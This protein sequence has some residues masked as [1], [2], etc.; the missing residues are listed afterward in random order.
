VNELRQLDIKRCLLSDQ[1]QLSTRLRGLKRYKNDPDRYASELAKLNEAISISTAIVDKRK[2]SIPAIEFPPD[3]P[4]SEQRLVIAEAMSKNQ[5]IILAGDTGSGKTTQLPK[6]CLQL[7]L[8]AR[9]L[10]GHTQPRRLAARSVS[11]RIADEL[12]VAP[13]TL[14]GCQVRFS[15]NTSSDTLVKLM[16]DGILLAEI[17]QD[18]YLN[19]YEVLI[20]DEAHERSLNIDFLL[21]YLFQLLPKRPDLKL[22]ITSATIDVEK[23]SKHFNAAP[24]ITVAGRTFPVDIYYRPP[25]P[26]TT[27][28]SDLDDTLISSIRAAIGEIERLE[29][30][31][32]TLFGDIL[33]FLSG[34]REIRDLSTEFRKSP[35]RNT[36]ILPLYARLSATEQSRI[37]SPHTGRRLILSTNVAETSLTVPGIVYVIDTGLARISRYSPQSKVQRLP[38]EAISQSSANQRAGRCGRVS[39]GICIRLYSEDDYAARPLYTDP[40][41]LRTNLSAVILQMLMLGLGDVESFPFLDQPDQKSIN[42]GF[43]LLYELGAVDKSRKLSPMGRRMAALPTDPRLSRMLL[44]AGLRKCLPEALV[45][46]SA[47]SVQDPREFPPDK[48]QAAREKHGQFT[49]HESD[50]TAWLHLWSAFEKQRVNLSHS[51]LRQFCQKNFLSY[52]RLREWRETHRQ[53]YLS[54]Q[55]IGVRHSAGNAAIDTENIDYEAIHRA[56]LTGSLNQIGQKLEEGAYLGVRGRKF[57]LFPTSGLFKR[58]PKWI[59]TGELIETSRLY[60]TLAARIQPEWVVDAAPDLIKRDY[61]EAHWEKQRGEVVAF[62]KISLYGLTLIERRRVSYSAIDPK[63]CREIFIREALVAGELLTRAKFFRNNMNL[64]DEI[65]KEED[66]LRRPDLIVSEEEIFNYY[67]ERIPLDIIDTQ[68]LEN[69]LKKTGAMGNKNLLFM[70]KKDLLRRDIDEEILYEF[71]NQTEVH[72]NQLSID[73]RFN[74]GSEED[75]A[76]INVPVS[77]LPQMQEADLDWAIPGQLRDRCIALLKSLPKASRKLFIPIPDFVELFLQSNQSIDVEEKNRKSLIECLVNFIKV[78]KGITI[79]RSIFDPLE[80][81]QHLYPWLRIL[82][83]SGQELARGQSLHELKARFSETLPSKDIKVGNHPIEQQKLIDWTFG[84]LPS[85]VQLQSDIVITRYTALVDR[86]DFVDI[87]LLENAAKARSQSAQGLQRLFMLKTPQQRNMIISR[88]KLLENK[89]AL[90]LAVNSFSFREDCLQAIYQIAFQSEN[91]S[92]P[93]NQHEFE[94]LL[95]AGKSN[96]I[97]TAERIER[98]LLRIVELSYDLNTKIKLL[99]HKIPDTVLSDLN[100]HLDELVYPG[101]LAATP[102]RRLA[103]LPRY[104]ESALVRLEKLPQ[105]LNRDIEHIKVLDRFRSILKNNGWPTGPV[106]AE[107]LELRWLLEELRVSLFA[108]N[109]KTTVPISEKRLGKIVQDWHVKGLIV[110]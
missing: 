81:P 89:L 14:V 52:L 98:L 54:T 51:G 82:D 105:Q 19:K 23:F 93:A 20:I 101:C 32:G 92:I 29:R 58:N 49:D 3:L 71:P 63:L 50:F 26:S 45:I 7:G 4:V 13:G 70:D 78:H 42:D 87:I 85:A 109:L 24:V 99:S 103:D 6:I 35:L 95:V 110:A 1:H 47:L 16:T 55:Q 80:M 28:A 31:G 96:L 5:V 88:L 90:K 59:L 74:P 2:A 61:S 22:I 91:D 44:E 40:E 68:S 62:E 94:K 72:N 38:I 9:G 36:E 60:A 97:H 65:R 64:I 79:N 77:M 11:T 37:F 75:G 73:Y 56:I 57:A 67:S 17:Q 76:F 104:L 69:W 100:T 41:I 83:S 12:G 25:D 10:I 39:S 46:V 48:R 30:S 18:R 106:S 107:I 43:K 53:L 27:D 84:D 21:G 8:G 33:V 108:Q 66:K 15:D 86:G 102:G 34:E